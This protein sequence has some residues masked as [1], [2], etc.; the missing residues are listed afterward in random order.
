M[1][2]V[3]KSDLNQTYLAWLNDPEVNKFM[4]RNTKLATREDLLKYYNN[5]ARNKNDFLFAI[6]VKEN[7]KHIG[8]VRLGPIDRIH[9]RSDFG[10]MIGDKQS[11]GKGFAS[12]AIK[13]VLNYGF[14]TLK[15]NKINLGVIDD[16]KRAIALYKKLGFVKE[17]CIRK[18]F[19]F[20]GKYL[21]SIRM[22]LLREEFLKYE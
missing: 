15:I 7:N 19:Y 11:W 4:H 2:K 1:R 22:G 21:D 5:F 12:E 3:N 18:N 14:K 6:I 8:N 9:K 17:G 20:Q 10:I 13:L 16:N